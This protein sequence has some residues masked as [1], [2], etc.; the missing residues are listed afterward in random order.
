MFKRFTNTYEKNK[1]FVFYRQD[2]ILLIIKKIIDSKSTQIDFPQF[3]EHKTYNINL[4][5]VPK[6]SGKSFDDYLGPKN[7]N[8]KSSI[9]NNNIHCHLIRRK[10]VPYNKW[11]FLKI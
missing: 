3:R 1:T 7:F 5:S 6:N 8:K 11:Q 2:R 10:T 4:L 9:H